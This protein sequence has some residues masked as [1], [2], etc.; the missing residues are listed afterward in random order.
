MSEL[1]SALFVSISQSCIEIDSGFEL[2]KMCHQRRQIK[3]LNLRDKRGFDLGN[4]ELNLSPTK[5]PTAKF[6]F[7]FFRRR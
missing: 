2:M 5:Y 3:A 6:R 7:H 1:I 4:E